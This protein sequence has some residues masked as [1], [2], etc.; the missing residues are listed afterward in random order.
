MKS[1]SVQTNKK[2]NPFIRLKLF[3]DDTSR[4]GVNLLP[5]KDTFKRF[6]KQCRSRSGSS[7]RCMIGICSVMFTRI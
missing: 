6:C 1:F 4:H 7:V 3:L 2:K 5:H